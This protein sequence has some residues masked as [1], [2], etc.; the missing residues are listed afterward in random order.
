MKQPEYLTIVYQ[1][2]DDGHKNQL[3]SG[4]WESVAHGHL[5]AEAARLA[6]E[7]HELHTTIARMVQAQ[8]K[9]SAV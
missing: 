1:V 6:V 8:C 5:I 7:N 2:R 9:P 3:L 4:D